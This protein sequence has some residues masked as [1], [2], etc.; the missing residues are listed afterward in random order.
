M[1]QLWRRRVLPFQENL[2]TS[3]AAELSTE[4]LPYDESWPQRFRRLELRLEDTLGRYV[5]QI[6]H[7]GATAVPGTEAAGVIDIRL[8][9]KGVELEQLAVPLGERG[10]FSMGV[11]WRV[12]RFGYA[13]PENP[14]RL[15]VH[16]E[17][18]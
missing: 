8:W 12:P 15:F 1:D 3:Q 17:V 13:D 7:V 9:A 16:T 2:K 18:R 11:A 6:E 14:A 10:W 5:D 4:L